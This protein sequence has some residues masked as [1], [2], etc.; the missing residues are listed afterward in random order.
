MYPFAG[1][2]PPITSTT[3]STS[4]FSITSRISVVIT[5]G[6]SPAGKDLF[7]SFL[8]ILTISTGTPSLLRIRSPFLRS[9]STTPEPTV[10]RPIRPM[11]ILFFM[12]KSLP[13][14]PAQHLFDPMHG[15]PDTG[16]IL[17]QRKPDIVIPIFTEPNPRQHGHIPLCE[18]EL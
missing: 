12:R 4:G 5:S 9:M 11:P 1:S 8:T 6:D 18:E 17:H 14:L 13:I 15:L 7:V 10:P 16:L 3:M 2:N